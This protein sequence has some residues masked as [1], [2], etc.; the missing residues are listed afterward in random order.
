MFVR[1]DA[2]GGISS[3]DFFPK[4]RPFEPVFIG[5]RRFEKL[6]FIEGVL[7]AQGL[8][9]KGLGRILRGIPGFDAEKVQGFT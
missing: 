4:T 5:F 6:R 1:Q 2:G 8:D 9:L 7:Q 3:V